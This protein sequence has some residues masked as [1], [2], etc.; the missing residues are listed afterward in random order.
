MRN[1]KALTFILLLASISPAWSNFDDG[2]A[3]YARGDYALALQEFRPLAEQGDVNAQL[4]LGY[5][6]DVGHGVTQDH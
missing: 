1:L 3:A 6:Y 2:V 4:F 5:L